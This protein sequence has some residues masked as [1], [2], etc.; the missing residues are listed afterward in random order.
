MNKYF[1]LA[2]T[3]VVF[4]SASCFAQIAVRDEVTTDSVNL[5][6]QY[7]QTHKS[8]NIAIAASLIL[9]GSGHQY[10]GRNNSAL[11]YLA[12]DIFSLVGAIYSEK[13]SR[14]LN[15]DSKGFAGLNASANGGNDLYWQAV[16]DFDDSKSYNDAVDLNRD[17]DKRYDSESKQWFWANPDDRTEYNE[18]RKTARKYHLVSSICIGAMVLN[19]VISVVDIR[20]SSKYKVLKGVA[21]VKIVPSISSDLSS[22][23]VLMSALF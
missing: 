2:I 18:I 10:L 22:A 21:S 8:S 15:I 19:R 9:P 12:V 3:F 16:G 14:R 11:A 5:F 1:Y 17:K 23:G 13:Y 7:D 6:T 4:I 20:A